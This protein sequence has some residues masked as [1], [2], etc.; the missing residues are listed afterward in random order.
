MPTIE[1]VVLAYA[2]AWEEIDERKR[3]ALLEMSWAQNGIFTSPIGEAVGREALVRHIEDFHQ[4]FAGHRFIFTSGMDV[5]HGRLRFT[6]A[7]VG[8]E[9]SRVSEGMDFGEVDSDGRLLRIT[10]FFGPLSPVPSSWAANSVLQS[11]AGE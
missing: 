2:A 9:G 1:E 5:H 7:M 3:R 6:W 11:A 8:P 10:G 4:R